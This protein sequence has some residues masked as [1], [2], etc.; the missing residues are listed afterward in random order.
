LVR[1]PIEVLVPSN[2]VRIE[3]G[4]KIGAGMRLIEARNLAM[5]E[6]LLTGESPAAHNEADAAISANARLGDRVTI[7]HAGT[8]VRTDR[9]NAVVA[10]TALHTVVGQLASLLD[11][12]QPSPPQVRR[13]TRF[14]HRLAVAM[15]VVVA[16]FGALEIVRGARTADISL[17]AIA[18]IVSAIPEGCPSR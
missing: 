8:I 18:L 3:S 17:L 7:L 1:L 13:M 9:G 10:A 2:I 15:L 12:P 5:D 14:T 16:A 11:R 6:G 4:E